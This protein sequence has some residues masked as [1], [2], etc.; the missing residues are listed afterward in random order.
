MSKT[1]YRFQKQS[2]PSIVVTS[3]PDGMRGTEPIRTC[4]HNHDT[5]LASIVQGH[6]V[7]CSEYWYI[8]QYFYNPAQQIHVL[9]TAD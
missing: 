5:T 7:R 4:S 8:L 6:C 3:F 9:L 1:D 2:G